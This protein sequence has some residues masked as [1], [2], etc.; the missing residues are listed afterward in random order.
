LKNYGSIP[1][2][3][4]IALDDFEDAMLEAKNDKDFFKKHFNL[5]SVYGKNTK[6]IVYCRSGGRSA[7][8]ESIAESLGFKA[9]NYSGSILDWS[10]YDKNV[11]AY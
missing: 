9:L 8:A 3:I 7:I 4:N 2:S 6:L 5:P 10:K 1:K 11:K